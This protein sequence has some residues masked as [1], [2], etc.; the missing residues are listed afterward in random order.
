M[1]HIKIIYLRPISK[2][3]NLIS[4][5]VSKKKNS[6]ASNGDMMHHFVWAV[7]RAQYCRMPHCNCPITHQLITQCE[8]KASAL[9]KSQL[10][11]HRLQNDFYAIRSQ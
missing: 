5:V 9:V 4:V 11:R 1:I 8:V 10:L 6:D 2:W 7:T 3:G